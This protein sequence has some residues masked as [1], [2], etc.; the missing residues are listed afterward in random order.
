MDQRE[1]RGNGVGAFVAERVHGVCS[2]ASDEGADDGTD[3]G[4]APAATP[5]SWPSAAV[6]PFSTTRDT[7]STI[8]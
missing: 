7:A 6:R 5:A 4:I 1:R 8:C 2:E 3:D